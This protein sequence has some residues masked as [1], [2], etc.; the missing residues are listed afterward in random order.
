MESNTNTQYEKQTNENQ[1]CKS[2][3]KISTKN[4]HLEN[5]TKHQY[6]N[7][8][9]MKNKTNNQYENK[10]TQINTKHNTK[11]QYE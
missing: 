9:E 2:I 4:K 6:E 5:D 8:G 1:Y 10:N 7:Y 3:R 11:N